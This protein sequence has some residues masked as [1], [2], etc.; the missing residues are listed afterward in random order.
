MDALTFASKA[1][2]SL[3]WPAVVLVVLFGFR[4]PISGLI[5]AIKEAKF[6]VKTGSTTIEGT[7][8]TIREKLKKALTRP[9]PPPMK[10]LVESNPV[11]AI[12][13]SWRSL[14]TTANSSVS[15]GIQIAPI[16]LA[17]LLLE[18][19]VLSEDEA[20][21]FY[22]L[23]EIRNEVKTPGAPVVS[24]VSSASYSSLANAL[25]ETIKKKNP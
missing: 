25:T 22:K 12:D 3:V 4:A 16:K 8:G 23:Y 1:I 14:E 11:E 2:E 17:G 6:K 13:A 10:D 9:L 20:D 21:A 15:A 18:K 19:N 24:N 5:D 7:L